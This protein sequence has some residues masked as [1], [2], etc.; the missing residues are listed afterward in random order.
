MSG[1]PRWVGWAWLLALVVLCG[2]CDQKRPPNVILVTWDTVRADHVGQAPDGQDTTPHWTALSESGVS[3]T[4]TRTPSPITLPAHATILTGLE[5]PGHGVRT[6]GL[7]QLPAD[8]P[9]LAD[10]LS[11][12]GW[13]TAA[14]VSASVLDGAYGL[15]RGF[16]HYD[17]E[18]ES[19]P[20]RRLFGERRASASV[21]AAIG[22]LETLEPQTPFF[23]WL[24]LF[25]PH[26]PYEPP[27]DWAARYPDDPYRGEVAYTDEQ[28]GRFIEALETMGHLDSSV[29]VL[30]A[31]H[32]EGLGEHGEPT[33]AY[34]VY[35]TTMRVPMLWWAGARSGVQLGGT[36]TVTAP[37]T[38]ADIAPTLADLL[39]LAPWEGDGISLLG[40]MRGESVAPREFALECLDPVYVYSTAP[41]FA[42]VDSAGDS[43]VD[44]PHRERYHLLGDPDQVT[45]VYDESM[46]E[47]ADALF[48]RHQ[49]HW[50]PETATTAID[51]E[52]LARL[53][54][55][56]YVSGSPTLAEEGSLDYETGRDPKELLPVLALVTQGSGIVTADQGLARADELVDRFGPLPVLAVYRS[57]QLVQLGR[58]GEAIQ[59][60]EAGVE[61]NPHAERLADELELRQNE[62]A[63]DQRLA[64]AIREALAADP[65]HPTGRFD[66]AAVLHRL[67]ELDE[68]EALYR[69][70][71]THDP[72]DHEARILLARL[73]GTRREYDQALSTLEQGRTRKGHD[74][75]LDCA[76][77]DVLAWYLERPEEARR[78]FQACRLGGVELSPIQ[79]TISESP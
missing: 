23:L 1:R 47:E 24:H 56:G 9:T 65:D 27:A 6:N 50:P 79:T 76:A 22:W 53:E 37:A 38:L 12:E 67:E 43:W 44:L 48:A 71:L 10:R 73:L 45:N 8:H 14:F 63:D 40:A 11:A 3:F 2:C 25:D 59:A 5:P 4:Q 49:R 7:F 61:S 78:A 33:H 29:L 32:G 36:R 30:T 17:D 39:G 60:L 69:E 75:E 54:A 41:V 64:A 34:F 62:L 74:P 31:D 66:L 13:A 28:T 20:F 55:L 16:G 21:D 68:A 77:G 15:D 46:S 42:V 52:Q 57:D 26:L 72:D 18:V 70:V 51:P 58:R 19:S 35:E